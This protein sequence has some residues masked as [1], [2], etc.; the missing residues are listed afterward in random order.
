METC[1]NVY[2]ACMSKKLRENNVKQNIRLDNVGYAVS[3]MS[4]TF[5]GE[6]DCYPLESITA[7]NMF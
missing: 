5:I 3:L 6:I 7:G 2:Y 4:M 1:G